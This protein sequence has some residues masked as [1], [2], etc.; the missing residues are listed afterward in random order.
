[1]SYKDNEAV[2]KIMDEVRKQIGRK[3]DPAKWD[4]ATAW[5]PA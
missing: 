4:D 5:I 2:H 1:M 3:F